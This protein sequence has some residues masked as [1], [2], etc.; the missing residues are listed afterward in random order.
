MYMFVI[1]VIEKSCMSTI[2]CIIIKTNGKYIKKC[3]LKK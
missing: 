2:S 3:Y 1:F